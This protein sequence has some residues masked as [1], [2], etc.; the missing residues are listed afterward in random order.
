MIKIFIFQKKCHVQ[1]IFHPKKDTFRGRY[2]RGRYCILMY[3]S[4]VCV[5][6]PNVNPFQNRENSTYENCFVWFKMKLNPK[7]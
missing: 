2:F 3:T 4:V 1:V 7:P 5:I 6:G